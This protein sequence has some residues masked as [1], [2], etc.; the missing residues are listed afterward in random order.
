MCDDVVDQVCLMVSCIFHCE[1]AVFLDLAVVCAKMGLKIDPILLNGVHPVPGFNFILGF[2]RPIN[3]CV[4]GV[5][6]MD[7]CV[8]GSSQFPAF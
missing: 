1:F 5:G 2:P 4:G 6:C 3:N 7:L 8:L